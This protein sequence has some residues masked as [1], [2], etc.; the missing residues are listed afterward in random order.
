[1][2]VQVGGPAAKGHFNLYDRNHAFWE[3][4]QKALGLWA[5]RIEKETSHDII[6]S[7][8]VPSELL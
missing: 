1:M 6:M 8:E 3:E 4:K 2:T 5:R 7:E